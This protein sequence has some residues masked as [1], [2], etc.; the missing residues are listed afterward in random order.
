MIW[1]IEEAQQQ[2]LEIIDASG[3]TPQLIYERDRLVVA[4]IRADLFQEFLT[5]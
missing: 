4:V 5:W 2:F 1:K 3:A